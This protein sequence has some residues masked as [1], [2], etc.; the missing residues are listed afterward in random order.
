M[1]DLADL[2]TQQVGADLAWQADQRMQNEADANVRRKINYGMEFAGQSGR[3]MS[4]F[5]K[6]VPFTMFNGS[7]DGPA[8]Q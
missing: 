7:D 5:L 3:N 1:L 8:N 6:G 4:A 2:Q